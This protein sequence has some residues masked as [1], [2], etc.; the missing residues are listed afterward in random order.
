MAQHGFQGRNRLFPPALTLWTFVL[1]VLSPDD[2]CREALSRVR[3]WQ[4]ATGQVPCSPH[5]GSYCKAR[6]RLPEGAL[7]ALARQ[8]GQRLCEQA[9]PAWLW[10]GRRVKLVDGS[11]V[12]MPD[13]PANQAA[14]PQQK[15]QQ[16][17]LG[18]PIARLV[19]VFDLASGALTALGVGP[20]Q[21]KESGELALFR[22]Q[23]C[24]VHRGDVVLAD[25]YYGSYW[26][27]AGLAQQG[28]DYVGR[29]HHRRKTDFRRAQRLGRE[30]HV[31]V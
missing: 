3:S 27:L 13:T 17:G 14:Y 19:G 5:T 29:Q 18:F 16:P 15:G 20:Y 2:S 6:A 11:T 31:V 7:A 4:I 1:Q 8:S 12:T 26:P 9:P 30:D 24:H 23:Q 10:K 28:L 21:G 25:R 22:Q